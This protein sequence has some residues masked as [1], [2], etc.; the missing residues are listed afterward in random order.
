MQHGGATV[1]AI[2][3]RWQLTPISLRSWSLPETGLAVLRDYTAEYVSW[4][5]GQ[6][7]VLVPGLAGGVGLVS[8]LAACLARHYQVFAYQLR[9]ETDPFVLRR[10]FTLADLVDDLAELLA[11]LRLERPIVLGVSFGGLIALQFAARYPHRLSAV[12]AQGVDVSFAPNLLRRVAAIVLRDYSLP[13]DS[14]FVNQF[15]NLFFGKRCDDPELFEFVTRQ[16][17]QT[18]QSVM[19]YRFRLAEEVNLRPYLPAI[20]VPTLLVTG[21]LDVLPTAAGLREIEQLVPAIEHFRIADA[22]HLA[23]VSHAPQLASII[24]RFLMR[25]WAAP[26]TA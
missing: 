22:G 16:C 14:P 1:Q 12:I 8:P 15:F 13:S 5:C 24:H 26:A 25:T 18:D 19:A 11:L 3:Q 20:R 6:P 2:R 9:G 17:W 21:Q 7:I 23:F 10:R 4:G